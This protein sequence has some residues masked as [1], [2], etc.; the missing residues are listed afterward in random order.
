[1]E[2]R[3]DTSYGK[4]A[5]GQ[6]KDRLLDTGKNGLYIYYQLYRQGLSSR[7][8]RLGGKMK[9]ICVRDVCDI[10]GMP[11][12]VTPEDEP[13]E[14]VI[15]RF[16][17]SPL[18]GGVFLVDSQQRFAGIVTRTSLLKW[19]SIQLSERLG[20]RVSTSDI[21]SSAFSTKAKDVA[22]GN[23]RTMGVKTT[24]DIQT[25]L[26]Q[27]IDSGVDYIPVLSKDGRVQ[28]SLGLS[29]V[30]LKALEAGKQSRK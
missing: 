24:D 7:E 3:K 14:N 19:A 18:C 29:Q 22:R 13:L 12:V 23:W 1:M 25:A 4:A 11:C 15:R 30:L 21:L 10:E 8:T 27:M 2:P 16:A 5:K 20:G 26:H 9:N 28:G 6:G 17:Q